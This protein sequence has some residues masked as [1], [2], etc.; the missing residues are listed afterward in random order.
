MIEEYVKFEELFKELNKLLTNPCN[1]F[2][3][4]G[5]VLLRQGLKPGTKDIDLVVSSRKEF[6]ALQKALLDAKFQT[7]RADKGYENMNLSQLFTR[8]DF[9]VDIFE[10]EVCGKFSLTDS[11]KSRAVK[12]QELSNLTVFHCSNEDIFL[13]KTMTGREGDLED[14]LELATTKL[15]WSAI[16][17]EMKLQIKQ[18]GIAVWVTWIGER[19]DLLVDKGLEIP[20]MK[21]LNVLRDDYFNNLEQELEKKKK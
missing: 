20:I 14:C 15:E 3:I 19:M 1:L 21:E 12:I 7:T 2:V 6:L 13:F 10:N 5:A 4:G 11:M 18:N 17:E 9:R 8:E 16:L